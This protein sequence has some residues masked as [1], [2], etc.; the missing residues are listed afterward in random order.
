MDVNRDEELIFTGDAGGTIILGNGSITS[1]FE[2]RNEYHEHRCPIVSIIWVGSYLVSS[3]EC[4]IMVQFDY[5]NNVT[6]DRRLHPDSLPQNIVYL[7]QY[8]DANF[9]VSAKVGDQ[10]I[11]LYTVDAVKN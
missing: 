1:G 3:D 6:L 11:Y 10:F 8:L 2:K 7:T 4:G 5:E 9:G